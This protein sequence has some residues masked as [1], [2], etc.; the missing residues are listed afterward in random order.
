MKDKRDKNSSYSDKYIAKRVRMPDENRY[1]KHKKKYKGKIG[2][3][4]K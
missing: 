2:L 3:L 1:E 4:F